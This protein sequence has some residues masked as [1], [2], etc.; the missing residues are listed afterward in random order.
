MA[1]T[2]VSGSSGSP[3]AHV[4][5][6]REHAGHERLGDVFHATMMRLPELQHW[7]TLK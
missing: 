1:P 2:C 5:R 7:P 6:Q 4:P 3:K